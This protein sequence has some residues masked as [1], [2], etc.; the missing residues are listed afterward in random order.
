MSGRVG[1]PAL[2]DFRGVKIRLGK[3]EQVLEPDQTP[4]FV[5]VQHPGHVKSLDR[6]RPTGDH[7]FPRAIS[8]YTR[9]A[10]HRGNSG[11][12]TFEVSTGRNR[13]RHFHRDQSFAE[14]ENLVAR[15]M[16]EKNV[17]SQLSA[18]F[19]SC[20]FNTPGAEGNESIPMKFRLP[21]R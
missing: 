15:G 1:V 19:A 4:L 2:P 6:A 17:I 10:G 18:M 9:I 11:W 7:Q 21:P 3:A 14:L 20:Q 16:H 13:T 12:Q 8:G 5:F